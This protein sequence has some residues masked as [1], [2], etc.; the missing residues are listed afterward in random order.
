[1]CFRCTACQIVN[2]TTAL[3]ASFDSISCTLP[4]LCLYI[5][6]PIDS[7]INVRLRVYYVK[8]SLFV[9]QCICLCKD[10]IY[11]NICCDYQIVL[12][13]LSALPPFS[14]LFKNKVNVS[15][16]IVRFFL[17]NINV[18]TLIEQR[19]YVFIHGS[20]L[21]GCSILFDT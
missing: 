13:V 20:P 9:L 2:V 21:F 14:L 18:E 4:W 16:S 19:S 8:V 10:T 15:F 5:V 17:I 7:W 3:P 12:L 11:Y 1:M 6:S